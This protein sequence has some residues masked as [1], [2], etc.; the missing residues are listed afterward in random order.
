MKSF[1]VVAAL[2][3]LSSVPALAQPAAGG[4]TPPPASG[5]PIARATV[6]QQV[7]DRFAMRDAN[8]NGF[9]TN[10]EL[11]G[12]AVA[13]IARLDSDHDGRVSL[14]EAMARTLA[15]FDAVDTNHDGTVTQAE[16]DAVMAAPPAATPPAPAQPQGH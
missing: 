7:R 9:M 14:P 1:F 12:N 16:A 4:A 15:D 3:A 13:I 2:V 8:H 6:E 11:G 10:D 5:L